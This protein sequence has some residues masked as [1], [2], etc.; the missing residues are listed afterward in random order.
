MNRPE[1]PC[2]EDL[3]YHFTDC[4]R[5]K[6][7]PRPKKDDF[8]YHFTYCVIFTVENPFLF[9]NLRHHTINKYITETHFSEVLDAHLHGIICQTF[10]FPS[11]NPP[12]TSLPTRIDT[13]TCHTNTRE[14]SSDALDAPCPAD[15]GSTHL[16]S[17]VPPH[18]PRCPP[19]TSCSGTPAPTWSRRRRS[20][21]F[22]LSRW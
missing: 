16:Q 15:I 17:R 11:A 18:P 5:L 2:E 9:E 3:D 14:R 6:K 4:V 21:Y 20:S 7:F 10:L 19:G 13:L 12:T 1:Q 22:L 8:N